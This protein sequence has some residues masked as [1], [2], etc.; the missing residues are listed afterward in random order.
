MERDEMKCTCGDGW[1]G[2]VPIV[3][4]DRGQC[5]AFHLA[6]NIVFRH[7]DPIVNA[8]QMVQPHMKEGHDA[9]EGILE[10]PAQ[11]GADNAYGQEVTGVFLDVEDDKETN[12]P[13]GYVKENGDLAGCDAVLI[14]AQAENICHFVTNRDGKIHEQC[15]RC[16]LEP[17]VS[18]GFRKA[19][20]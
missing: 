2:C 12:N 20:R 6:V 3:D 11:R 9:F 14:S 16:N 5:D 13:H 18:Y 17:G 19:P 7:L 15:Q 4:G 8:Q 10:Y 1:G